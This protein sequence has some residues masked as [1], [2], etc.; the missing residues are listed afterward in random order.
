M[1][2]CDACGTQIDPDAAI[3]LARANAVYCCRCYIH[4]V[5]AGDTLTRERTHSAEVLCAE[6]NSL[7]GP[8]SEKSDEIVA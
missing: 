6:P 3:K 4:Q 1:Q 8:G 5:R 7:A 2:Q